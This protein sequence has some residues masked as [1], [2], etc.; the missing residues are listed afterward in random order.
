MGL[1]EASQKKPHLVIN[2]LKEYYGASIGVSGEPQKFLRLLQEENESIASWETR[3]R[4]QGAQCEYE[5]FTDEFMRDQFIASTGSETLHVKLIEEGH[6]HKVS[7]TKVTL[8]EVVEVPKK[9]EATMYANQLMKTTRVT[10]E[11]VNFTS[12]PK[13]GQQSS[14]LPSTL[15]LGAMVTIN[16][17]STTLSSLREEM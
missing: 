15:V 10:Q 5:N 13:H 16:N 6:R 12:K 1:S 7:Q 2:A 3:R 14:Q 17:P 9:F 4:N 8:R 11:Q